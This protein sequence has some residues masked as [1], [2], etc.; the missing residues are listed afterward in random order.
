MKLFRILII[1]FFSIGI[2]CQDTHAQTVGIIHNDSLSQVGY[3]LLCP[4]SSRSSYLIDN[5]GNVVNQ[6]QSSFNP[7]LSCYLLDDGSLLRTGRLQ[8]NFVA[9]GLG[10]LIE[11][12]NWDGTLEWQYE[13][14]TDTTHLHHDIEVLP[15]GN[16]LAL[17]WDLRT[18]EDA[19]DLG[20]I[21]VSNA[22]VM[23]EKIV[24]LSPIG[25]DSAELIWEWFLWDHMIQEFDS[26]KANYGEVAAHPELWDI[27]INITGNNNLTD[28]I[29][30]NGIDYNQELDQIALSSRH[31]HEI[32]IIDHSTTTAEAASHSGG[33]S[34]KGGD[35]LYRWGNPENY[36]RGSFLEQ[37]LFGQHNVSWI[38]AGYPGEG[39]LMVF[40]NGVNR[41]EG[42]FSTVDVI[43]PP[44]L[45]DSTYAL[46]DALAFEPATADWSYG[47]N[48]GDEFFYSSRISGVERLANGNTLICNGREGELIEIDSVGILRWKYIL[49]LNG[50]SPVEQGASPTQNDLF[51]AVKY[52]PDFI[53]FD[54]KELVSREPIELN[55]TNQDCINAVTTLSNDFIEGTIEIF[56]NPA[57]TDITLQHTIKEKINVEIF[58][59]FGHSLFAQTNISSLENISLMD[60][61]QGIYFVQISNQNKSK[62][63]LEKIIKL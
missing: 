31:F 61:P 34:G 8:G 2:F 19:L 47:G 46:P 50:N 25:L 51:R 53:G 17:S 28:W 5:C 43:T 12:Y 21:G 45:G 16:I 42:L 56:P 60:I 15:N 7:G 57:L 55:P 33:N 59:A 22:G 20:R 9:G 6:W 40:N 44:L 54:G 4:S 29:H 3:T 26:T 41:P 1:F 30:F 39:S 58:N 14:A 37:R 49:P 27:N 62:V 10:G 11:R 52:S 13:I 32:Y 63:H 18:A 24:E 35:I 36:H 38:K 23:S 48:P